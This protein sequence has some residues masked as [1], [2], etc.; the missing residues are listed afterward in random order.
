M[1]RVELVAAEV[2]Q[3]NP[4]TIPPAAAV[5]SSSFMVYLLLMWSYGAGRPLHA[6][7]DSDCLPSH[8]W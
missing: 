5:S 7:E 8:P 1:S 3:A 2:V 6:S 4:L